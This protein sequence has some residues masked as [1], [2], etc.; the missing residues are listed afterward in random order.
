MSGG[1][2]ETREIKLLVKVDGEQQLK[3][4]NT[5]LKQLSAE[6]KSLDQETK[7]AINAQRQ[8]NAE[9]SK[10]DKTLK[11]T[12]AKFK[13][14][15]AASDRVEKEMKEL[16]AAGQTGSARFKALETQLTRMKKSSGEFAV[17]NRAANIGMRSFALGAQ[18]ASYQITDFIVQ[19]Q[20]GTSAIRAAGQQ[21]PQLLGGFG[22]IGAVAGLA[23]AGLAVLLESMKN[24]ESGASAFE[25]AMSRADA[26]LS[27]FSDGVS[28]VNLEDFVQE[29]SYPFWYF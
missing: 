8:M 17:A 10:L 5:T 25:D 4:I 1:S 3:S 12:E 24:T 7:D 18:N 20:G 6:Y 28:N 15:P 13:V 23:A 29:F 19:V 22:A 11:T 14:L 27:T 26:A 9:M 21:L 16:A 2:T